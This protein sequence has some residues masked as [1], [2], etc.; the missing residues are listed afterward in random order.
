MDCLFCKIIA[1]EIPSTKLY[2]DEKILAF[3]DINAQAPH[4]FLVI[5]KRHIQSIS[6]AQPDDLELLGYIQLK[7]AELAE[8]EGISSEGYRVVTNIGE[9]GGQ[10]V[11]HLHYHVLGGRSMK[12]PPG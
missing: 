2:E 7:I 6:H 12:W 10:A 3:K 1:G 5:P 11:D 8:I 9:A 4:H